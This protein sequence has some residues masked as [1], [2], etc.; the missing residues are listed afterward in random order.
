MKAVFIDYDPLYGYNPEIQREICE[1]NG[2]EYVA[3]NCKT[4][5]E[6]IEACKDADAV[7]DI[8]LQITPRVI[9]SLDHCKVLVRFGIGYNEIDVEAATKKGIFVCNIPDYCIEEVAT[10]AVALILAI[11]RKIEYYHELARQGQWYPAKGYT[12]HRLSTQTVGFIGFGNI[13]R[14]AAHYMSAFGCRLIAYDPFLDKEVFAANNAEGMDLDSLLA[15]ADIISLHAPLFDDTY[16]I[17]NKETIKKMK[18]GAMVVN[19]SRGPLICEDDLL[20]AI[21]SGKLAAAGLDVTEFEPITEPNYRL[22][23]SDRIVVTPH[24]AFLTAE[25]RIELTQKVALTACNILNGVFDDSTVR[26]IVNR[27]ALSDKITR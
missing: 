14:K 1:K 21:Q 4:E 8:F 27:K 25:S 7:L 6:I 3:V 2:I 15:Q 13:A 26:R 22:F 18:D 11:S 17:I 20:E 23:S 9:E 5:D 24:A 19:T 10:H 12:M 16:H